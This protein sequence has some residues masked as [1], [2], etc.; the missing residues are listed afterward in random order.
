[1]FFFLFLFSLIYMNAIYAVRPDRDE[2]VTMI[3]HTAPYINLKIAF[4]VLQMAV[5]YFGLKVAW[6]GLKFSRWFRVGSIVHIPLLILV[7]IAAFVWILNALGDMGEKG[8]SGLQGG[9]GCNK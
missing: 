1:M 4:C 8:G 6:V 9:G 7:T 2:P 3:I 5:V